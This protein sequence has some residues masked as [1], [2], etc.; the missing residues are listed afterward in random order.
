[1]I[2]RYRPD[3]DE[4]GR[5]FDMTP[6]EG[7]DYVAYE[8]YKELEEENRY[9]R[10]GCQD[11]THQCPIVG[12][13]NSLIERIAEQQTEI[14]RLREAL[15]K[16]LPRMAHRFE[17][18]SVLPSEMWHQSGSTSL[19]SCVCE[20]KAVKAALAGKEKEDGELSDYADDP[21][22]EGSVKP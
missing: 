9:L 1:M 14:E 18:V 21:R 5:S 6:D 16:A 7:G 10:A 2:Q 4:Q 8:D 19:D 22:W 11:D 17:C 3:S 20:I 15:E 12:T 13:N